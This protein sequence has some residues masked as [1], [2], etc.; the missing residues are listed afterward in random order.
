MT[1]TAHYLQFFTD[2]N[3]E[4]L[5]CFAW[6]D[7]PPELITKERIIEAAYYWAAI[8][9]EDL[10]LDDLRPH[11]FWLRNCA[12]DFSEDVDGEIWVETN[13]GAQGAL[14][15]TGVV[16]N[17]PPST[18]SQADDPITCIHTGR[19][20]WQGPASEAPSRARRLP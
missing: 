15:V 7:I 13:E 20:T 6:G 3:D 2:E 8:E 9:P 18:L 19:S 11:A 12:D 17:E 16:F 5:I 10:S 4:P 14:R 1:R